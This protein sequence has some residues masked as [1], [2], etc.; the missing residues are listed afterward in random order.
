MYICKNL[1]KQ[2]IYIDN[3]NCEDCILY[4]C[5][6]FLGWLRSTNWINNEAV[7]PSSGQQGAHRCTV[8]AIWLWGKWEVCLWFFH[9]FP[10][11]SQVTSQKL[12][13]IC[14]V[15]KNFHRFFT[16][17]GNVTDSKI[18]IEGTFNTVLKPAIDRSGATNR[19]W[20]ST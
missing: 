7:L 2:N 16:S 9:S 13:E 4:M 11:T 8:Y 20:K 5:L 1:Q 14:C 10:F 15:K 17:L 19:K 18:I 6:P 12:L 3:T